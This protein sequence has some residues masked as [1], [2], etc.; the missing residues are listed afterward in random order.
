MDISKLSDQ[1]LLQVV[2]SRGWVV[3]AVRVSDY[4]S[5]GQAEEVEWAM[6]DAAQ[7]MAN[8]LGISV[9]QPEGDEE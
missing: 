2:R 3:C 8:S 6:S 7:E 4:A 1:D 5:P 9:W